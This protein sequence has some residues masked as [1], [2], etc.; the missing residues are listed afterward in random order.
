MASLRRRYVQFTL[1]EP[2]IPFPYTLGSLPLDRIRIK[3]FFVG[4][5]VSSETDWFFK[6]L[7][8]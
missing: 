7:L 4:K 2:F 1:C 6:F 5:N 3:I 8:A